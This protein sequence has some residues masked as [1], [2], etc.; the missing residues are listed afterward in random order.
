VTVTSAPIINDS[1]IFRVSM[2]KKPLPEVSD[3]IYL[4]RF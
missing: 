1:P 4:Q 2:S 3:R